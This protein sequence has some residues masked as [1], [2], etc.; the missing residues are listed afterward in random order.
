MEIALRAEPEGLRA[1]YKRQ[2]KNLQEAYG[3][4]IWEICA[5]KN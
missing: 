2:L 5:R 3:E 4:A 1:Q